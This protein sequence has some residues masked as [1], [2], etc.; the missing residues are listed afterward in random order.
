MAVGMP[1][2][3][4]HGRVIWAIFL[5]SPR[6]GCEGGAR[7]LRVSGAVVGLF[8][9][10]WSKKYPGGGTSCSSRETPW[11]ARGTSVVVRVLVGY[12]KGDVRILFVRLARSVAKLFSAVARSE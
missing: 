8:D 4:R 3:R 6:T 9:R 10:R 5:T 11:L 2:M 12:T 1:D 7:G